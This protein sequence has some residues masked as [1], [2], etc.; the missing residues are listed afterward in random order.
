[1]G[2]PPQGQ[3]RGAGEQDATDEARF[4]RVDVEVVNLGG[5][6]GTVTQNTAAHEAGHMFG[7]DD[8]YE[9][10]E[11]HRLTGDKPEH[12]GDVEAEL[13]TD[14]ANETLAGDSGNIMSVGGQ[15]QR[16]HYVPFLKGLETVTGKQWTIP[17]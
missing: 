10:T 5:G 15:V 4:Q 11:V 13:G 9:D 3:A 6:G 17:K 8:E 2:W 7:L 16:G 14:A 12:F 1:M